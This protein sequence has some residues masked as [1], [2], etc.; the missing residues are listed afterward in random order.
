MKEAYQNRPVYC[1]VLPLTFVFIFFYPTSHFAQEFLNGSFELHSLNECGVNLNNSVYSTAMQFSTAFGEKNEVDVL[2]EG[3]GFGGAFD[4][5]YFIALNAQSFTDA[6]A[7]ELSES[8]EAGQ[9]YV[10]TFFQKIGQGVSAGGLEIGLSANEESFGV[11][12]FSFQEISAQWSEVYIDFI[13]PISGRFIT[14]EPDPVFESW[15][16]IDHFSKSCPEAINLGA[17]TVV[18]DIGDLVLS[19]DDNFEHYR[20]QDNSNLNFIHV[21]SPGLYWVEALLNDCLIRDSILIETFP[22]NCQCQIFIPNVIT[23]NSDGINDKFQV[24]SPCAL[25]EFEMSIFDRWGNQV[26]AT[27]NP[28]DTWNI[29]TGERIYH[30]GVF[31]YLVKY[32]FEYQNSIN[33]ISGDVL[34]L[35]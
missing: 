9:R 27:T 12:V 1:L 35:Q 30:P 14:I 15:I 18:C 20:W 6:V 16:F 11:P 33:L 26:F 28:G 3:C 17:D 21:S 22:E 32:R 10:F 25:L 5:S 2:S 31:V 34:L 19:I 8:L 23:P 13:A 24:F 7:L 4:G 29:S